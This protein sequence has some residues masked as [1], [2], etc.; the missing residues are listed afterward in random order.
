[1][2]IEKAGIQLF[3]F[4]PHNGNIPIHR[5]IKRRL[6][7]HLQRVQSNRV[8]FQQKAIQCHPLANQLHYLLLGAENVGSLLLIGTLRE[9]CLIGAMTVK[10]NN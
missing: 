1:M 3:I 7:S 9:L 4:C 10:V 5:M 6:Q 2:E 8:F